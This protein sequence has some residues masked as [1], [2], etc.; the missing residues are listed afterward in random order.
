MLPVYVCRKV[1]SAFVCQQLDAHGNIFQQ[2]FAVKETKHDVTFS[3]DPRSWSVQPDPFAV[4]VAS[5]WVQ[6]WEDMTRE[7]SQKKT[8]MRDVRPEIYGTL[9]VSSAFIVFQF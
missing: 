5:S 6:S 1:L 2:T 4:K 7:N 9:Y 3:W 8:I